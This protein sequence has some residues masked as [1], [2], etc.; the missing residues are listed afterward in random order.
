VV[1]LLNRL[2][3]RDFRF[4]RR[5]WL[6]KGLWLLHRPRLNR[7]DWFLRR[8]RRHLGDRK[9]LFDDRRRHLGDRRLF[10]FNRRSI[11]GRRRGRRQHH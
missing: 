10:L 11:L 7:R 8:R 4:R 6:L 9:R 1:R 2:M 3:F 5:L